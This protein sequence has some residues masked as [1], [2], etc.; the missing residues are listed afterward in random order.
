MKGVNMIEVTAEVIGT[1]VVVSAVVLI[2]E[3]VDIIC[4]SDNDR[5]RMTIKNRKSVF[6]KVALTI[7]RSIETIWAIAVLGWIA[8]MFWLVAVKLTGININTTIAIL[9]TIGGTAVAVAGM[10]LYP[11]FKNRISKKEAEADNI[12]SAL[13]KLAELVNKKQTQQE[14]N[15]SRLNRIC[16][17]LE[18]KLQTPVSVSVKLLKK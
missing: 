13:E 2:L 9:L 3:L 14:E 11:K 17:R 8:N 18:E 10:L 16:E 12:K 7:F 15:L 5:D 4:A 6:S 1:F